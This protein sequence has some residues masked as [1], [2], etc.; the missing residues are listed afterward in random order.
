MYEHSLL[1][2]DA[3]NLETVWAIEN[4]LVLRYG[5]KV[6]LHTNSNNSISEICTKW[7]VFADPVTYPAT[8][9]HLYEGFFKAEEGKGW[10]LNTSLN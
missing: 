4:P 2:S 5:A 1:K 10:L 9:I 3:R 7:S 8:R 6:A